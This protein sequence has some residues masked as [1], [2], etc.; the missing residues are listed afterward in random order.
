MHSRARVVII[1]SGIAG[2]SIAYHLTELGWRDVLVLEQGGLI[3]GTTS[4][5]PGLVGQMRASPTLVKLLM[6]SVSLYDKLRVHGERGYWPVGSLRL[7][8]SKERL[9]ESKRL[10][11]LAK[12]AGLPAEMIGP[13][14]ARKLFPLMTTD[15]V[16]GALYFPTDGSARASI[17]AQALADGA[18][19]R[20]ASFVS[21]SRV[22]GFGIERGYIKAVQTQHGPI[23]AEHVV[24]ASGIWSPRLGRLAG[25]SIPLT[26]MQHQYAVT[27]P[28]A[29]LADHTVINLRDP[30][31][32][33]YLR[34][35]GQ[36]ISMGGYEHTPKWFE[37]DAIPDSENPTVRPFDQARYDRL[38]ELGCKRLPV[39]RS[40]KFQKQINGLESFT[41]DGEF[42]LGETAEV[43]GLWVACGFCAHGVSGGGGVGK[44]MAEWIVNG[45]PTLDMWHMDVRRFGPHTASRRYVRER[46]SEIYRRYYSINIPGQEKSSARELRLSPVYHRLKELGA[47]FGEKNGWERPNWFESNA[48]PA[49]A[50]RWLRPRGWPGILWSPAIG[51]EHIGTRERVGLFDETSFSKIE[52]SGPGALKFLQGI[53]ANQMDKPVGSVT[54]TQMLNQ[55]GGIECDLTVTRVAGDTFR[56]ITGTAF[57][58]HDLA[59]IRRHLPEDG[60]V[61]ARDVTSGWCCLGVWGPRARE[62]MTA[63]SENDFSNSAFPYLTAQN[64][65][66]G[67]IPVLAVR[68]TYV[69]ELGWELYCPMESGQ[70]LWTTLWEAGQP[71]GAVAAGYKA[72]DSLR[73]EKGYR[74]WSAEIS[75][76]HHP[77]EAGL[78]FAVKMNKGDFIGRAAL[79]R[80]KAQAPL[81]KLCCLTLDDARVV[82]MGGEPVI[83][84]GNVVGRVTSGGFGYSIGKSI[85]YSYLPVSLA[86]PGMRLEMEWFAESIGATVASE[87]LYD[88]KHEKIKC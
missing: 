80:L 52:V 20:G 79:E 76:E 44:A 53:A 26:P 5:P 68:V 21:Q 58:P 83:A 38:L 35:D 37:V 88:P 12:S 54:Y 9:D 63:V 82:A 43:R 56:I 4:H 87:P 1:G 28:L 13:A 69:G 39:L 66:V 36:S 59:W 70:K 30:D 34:Q 51:A 86:Q 6:Y 10:L 40:V 73:L 72:I 14:E 16:E 81:R 27:E 42:I 48:T 77:F 24:L 62:L 84:N 23:E 17:L 61:Q 65:L 3:S 85:A 78:G 49:E 74:Y 31:L 29:E 47:V 41:P 67:E 57:G 60:S 2:S 75:P 32:L 45:E 50:E 64:V 11:A 33:V 46:A 7:A 18:R 25:V 19:E 8:S 71:L 55:R 15:G 22:I